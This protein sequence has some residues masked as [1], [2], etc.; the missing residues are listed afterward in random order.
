MSIRQ[1]CAGP[2]TPL[3]PSTQLADVY[4]FEAKLREG[5]ALAH[6][7]TT[8]RH[9]LLCALAIWLVAAS[10]M[11][12]YLQWGADQ[13]PRLC[14]AQVF[15]AATCFVLFLYAH[16]VQHANQYVSRCN[17]VL[18]VFNI[19]FDQHTGKLVWVQEKLKKQPDSTGTA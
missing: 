3:D 5:I 10:A 14:T 15:T 6:A 18:K 7:A 12:T 13:V 2:A 19:A 9:L 8:K 4:L 16:R 1:N 11:W 17:Q